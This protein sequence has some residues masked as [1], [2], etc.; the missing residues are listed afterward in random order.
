[1][2]RTVVLIVAAV[3]LAALPAVAAGCG[4]GKSAASASP[5]WVKVLTT[6][7]PGA[8]PVKL[9][10]G[11]H[12]LGAAARLSWELS[13]PTTAPP[14]VLTFR[15]INQ[16]NG[17]GY[18]SSVSP[19]DPGFSLDDQDA[20]LLAPIWKGLYYVYFSQRFSQ[21]KGP[22]YDARITVWTLE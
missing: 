15:I 16:K 8:Q 5:Q 7:V 2:R 14:V 11:T 13:G 17:V 12:E 4:G 10:L 1:V 3:A 21:G 22:G 18:G 19:K 20:F 9:N 6:D